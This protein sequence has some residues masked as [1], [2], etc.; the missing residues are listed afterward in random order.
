[1]APKKQGAGEP[2]PGHNATELQKKSLVF[3]HARKRI[4]HNVAIK[5]AQDAKKEDGL[6]AK[7]DLEQYGIKLKDVD[8]LIGAMQAEDEKVVAD[9][10]N[11]HGMFLSWLNIAPGFQ[12]DL[13]KDRA[14][15]R[16]RTESAGELAGWRNAPRESGYAKD[17]EENQWW[18]AA[19]DRARKMDM[20]NLADALETAQ[21]TRQ[22]GK[23]SL[24]KKNKAGAQPEG[25][26]PPEPKKKAPPTPKGAKAAAL[27]EEKTNA[28]KE[29]ERQTKADFH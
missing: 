1:M 2:G 4:A 17:S 3:Y 23:T 5:E 20:E 14:T 8:F 9:R 22:A 16:E 18:L 25:D 24:L 10:F 29:G 12:P 7:A 21:K 27:A 6:K 19:Y 26:T 13:F 11:I 28:D 15:H